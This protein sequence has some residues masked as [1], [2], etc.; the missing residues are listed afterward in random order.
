[1][2]KLA[3]P[4]ACATPHGATRATYLERSGDDTE[5]PGV[6]TRAA[7]ELELPR[8]ARLEMSILPS[9]HP[10]VLAIP[11]FNPHVLPDALPNWMQSSIALLLKKRPP[12]CWPLLVGVAGS[13]L[14]GDGSRKQGNRSQTC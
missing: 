5:S 2:V 3:T 12:M 13:G 10:D 6:C 11:P 8:R 7:P 9:A 1:M 4:E 14:T